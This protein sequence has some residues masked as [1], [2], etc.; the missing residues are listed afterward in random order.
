MR[1]PL[2]E[3]EGRTPED[4]LLED[5]RKDEVEAILVRIDYG[6]CG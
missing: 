1:Q 4:V 2:A 5:G 6:V 3:S